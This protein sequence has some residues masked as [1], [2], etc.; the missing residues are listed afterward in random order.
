MCL[1]FTESM[2]KR[3]PLHPLKINLWKTLHLFD[4]MLFAEYY[5]NG[6][7]FTLLATQPLAD[8]SSGMRTRYL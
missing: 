4:V 6:K 8:D 7:P 1:D 2:T 5:D 3:T